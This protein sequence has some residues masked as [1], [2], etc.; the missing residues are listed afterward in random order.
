MEK[1]LKIIKIIDSSTLIGKG[2]KDEGVKQGLKFKIIG[3]NDG[4]EI[5]D[6]ETNESLGFLGLEKGIVIAEQVEDRFTVY[7]SQ[8][9]EEKSKYGDLAK[10]SSLFSSASMQGLVNINEKIPAHYQRLNVDLD[11]ITGSNEKS[12]IKIGDYL[13]PIK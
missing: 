5:L 1:K 3:K 8:F 13:R 12:A 4:E 11:E 9:I 2:G 7:R 10:R 6:P